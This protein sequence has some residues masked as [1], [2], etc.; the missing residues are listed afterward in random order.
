MMS[1]EHPITHV[2][3]DFGRHAGCED[4][5]GAPLLSQQGVYVVGAKTK[6]ARVSRPRE[7]RADPPGPVDSSARS[8]RCGALARRTA[9][10]DESTLSI[11]VTR[12]GPKVEE[13]E[14]V[15]LV[16]VQCLLRNTRLPELFH[17]HNKTYIFACSIPGTASFSSS[18]CCCCCCFLSASPVVVLVTPLGQRNPSRPAF[19]KNASSPCS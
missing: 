15:E 16:S 11:R 12:A 19:E 7:A 2:R 10:S 17:D 18:C 3:C 6:V 13:A 14:L 4:I 8:P 1:G 5:R 9:K